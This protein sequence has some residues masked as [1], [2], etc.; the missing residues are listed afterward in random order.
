MPYIPRDTKTLLQSMAAR[1]I[2]R[3]NLT[4]LAEGSVLLQILSA[5]AEELN[6]SELRLQNIRDSYFLRNVSSTDLDERA[7][8]MPPAGLVRRGALHAQGPVLTV[9]REDKTGPAGGDKWEDPFTLP[10]QSTFRRSDDPAKVYET[11]QDVIFPGNGG[12]AGVDGTGIVD[13]VF[14]KCQSSGAG[15]NCQKNLITRIDSAPGDVIAITNAEGIQNGTEAETDDQLKNRIIAYLSSLA[16]CQPTALEYL[17]LAFVD[18]NG[19]R[20]VFA[21]LWEDPADKGYSEL[22]VDDGSGLAGNVALGEPTFGT[23]PSHGQAVLYHMMPATEAIATIEVTRL[24]VT[25]VYKHKDGQYI[26]INE[27][28]LVYF[29]PGVLQPGDEWLITGYSVYTNLIANLQRVVEGSTSDP[30]NF[31]GWRAAGTRVVVAPAD[32][33]MLAMDLHVIPQQYIALSTIADELRQECVSF[34]KK[35]APGETFYVSQLIDVLM[36][37]PKLISLRIYEPGSAMFKEDDPAA[38]YRTAWRLDASSIQIVP[39]M[40]DI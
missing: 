15:G 7:A 2:A 39:A 31:P 32:V 36:G 33:Q 40:E 22:V 19:G 29:P 27:R 26:S 3:T 35:L 13:G 1:V 38:D 9:T 11:V 25:T 34:C 16:R 37:N 12:V 20:A 18:A 6:L 23:V 5:M 28:G 24:G 8:E 4:D 17:A 14:V 21:N 10:A 30:V